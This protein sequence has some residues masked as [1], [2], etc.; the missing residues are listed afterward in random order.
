VEIWEEEKGKE[1]IPPQKIQYCRIYR[2]WAA[3]KSSLGA[4]KFVK[5]AV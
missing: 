1:T 4:G 3:P 5:V 2:R